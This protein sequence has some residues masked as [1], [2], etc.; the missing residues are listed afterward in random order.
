MWLSSFIGSEAEKDIGT[1]LEPRQKA[2]KET[3]WCR[4]G[5]TTDAKG[6]GK[7]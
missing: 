2:E 4:L 5:T 7:A 1:Q 3:V 6:T